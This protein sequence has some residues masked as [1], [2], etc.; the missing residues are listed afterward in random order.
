MTNP[1]PLIAT[2]DGVDY[3]RFDC[4][5]DLWLCLALLERDGVE[6]PIP[7]KKISQELD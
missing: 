5:A 7:C 1:Q 3:H 4:V 2:V 6:V